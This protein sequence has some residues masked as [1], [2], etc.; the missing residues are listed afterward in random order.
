MAWLVTEGRVLASCESVSQRRAKGRGLLG[1]DGIEGA[2][3]LTAS[4]WRKSIRCKPCA[5][6][7]N[8][9]ERL[10][11]LAAAASAGMSCTFNHSGAQSHVDALRS[12]G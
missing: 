3:V 8:V 2:M 12:R 9:R 4:T 10:I 6:W 1:R 5:N 7:S 11:P